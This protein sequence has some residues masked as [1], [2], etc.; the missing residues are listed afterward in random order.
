[1]SKINKL[2]CSLSRNALLIL[3]LVALL[4]IILFNTELSVT[5]ANICYSIVAAGIFYYVDVRLPK[6]Y[7]KRAYKNIISH[8]LLLIVETLRLCREVVV[9]FD[10]N[11]KSRDEYVE[12]FSKYNLHEKSFSRQLTILEYINIKK[13]QARSMIISLLSYSQYLDFEEQKILLKI[14]DTPFFKNDIIAIDYNVPDNLLENK[15]NNQKE[16]GE[17]IYDNYELAKNF[18]LTK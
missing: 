5:C 2:L 18:N 17:S 10:F 1:M 3:V 12:I 13:E 9:K 15:Y 16:I 8:Q 14:L 11:I 6:Q 4:F 7:N